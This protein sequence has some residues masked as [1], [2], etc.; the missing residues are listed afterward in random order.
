MSFWSHTH[1]LGV[2]ATNY[3]IWSKRWI[4][5]AIGKDSVL[6]SKVNGLIIVWGR[7]MVWCVDMFNAKCI[8]KKKCWLCNVNT[9][10]VSSF[11]IHSLINSSLL[12]FHVCVVHNV[13]KQKIIVSFLCCCWSY[14]K[15]WWL[16][17]PYITQIF[18]ITAFKCKQY[19]PL[20]YND[21]KVSIKLILQK[22][23]LAKFLQV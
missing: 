20:T 23:V 2:Q 5:L 12:L 13:F 8:L 16:I 7:E 19:N 1:A 21:E 6:Y 10:E 4:Y 3:H 18:S 11:L 22:I 15:T 17:N 14:H 9:N